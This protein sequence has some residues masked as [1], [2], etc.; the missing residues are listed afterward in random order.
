[1]GQILIIEDE[2]HIRFLLQK[3]FETAGHTIIEAEDGLAALN[4][5][6]KRVEPFSLIVLD[7]RLPK[8]DGFEFLYRLRRQ[9]CSY[10]P[11]LVLTAQRNSCAK[12]IE[13]GADGCLAKPFNRRRLID[14]G[15][16]L[17][18]ANGNKPSS[19]KW[20]MGDTPL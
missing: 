10:I 16:H 18:D 11:V 13:N 2:A 4:I 20:Q 15:N 1:M 8:M 5:I 6:E 14:A 17:I 9:Q 3:V 19:F 7:I 12:I